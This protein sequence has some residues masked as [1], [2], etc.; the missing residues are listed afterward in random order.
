MYKNKQRLRQLPPLN[1]EYSFM[2]T[3]NIHMVLNIVLD[4]WYVIDIC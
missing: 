2:L 4:I 1:R 3:Y